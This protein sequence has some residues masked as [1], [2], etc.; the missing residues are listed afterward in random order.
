MYD[1]D[2]DDDDPESLKLVKQFFPPLVIFH[3]CHLPV[4]TQLQYY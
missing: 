4:D 2:D 3:I 1:N